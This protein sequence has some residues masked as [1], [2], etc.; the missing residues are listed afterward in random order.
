MVADVHFL[1]ACGAASGGVV[2]PES[3]RQGE[4]DAVVHAEVAQGRNPVAV[5]CLVVHHE[6]EGFRR[7]ALVEELN[8]V[9]GDEVGGVAFLTQVFA[10]GVLTAEHGVVVRALVVEH[11]IVV[12]A[13]GR[14]VEVPLAHH[15]RLVTGALQQFGY[16]GLGGVDALGQ[17]ALAVL[18]AVEAGDE[19][20]P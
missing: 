7:V 8:G 14:A 17:L 12:E 9:V 1:R 6:T 2:V 13:L 18:V 19:A 3:G 20:G 11:V 4:V 16:V 10:A 15:G 5:G